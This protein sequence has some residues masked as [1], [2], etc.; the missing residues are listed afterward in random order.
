LNARLNAEQ[1]GAAEI[2]FRVDDLEERL[3]Q[4]GA[5]LEHVKAERAN[6]AG[7]QSSDMAMANLYHMRDL[8]GSKL[9]IEQRV[10][11]EADKRSQA[12]EE[13]LRK[14]SAELERV[15]DELSKQSDEQLVLERKLELQLAAAKTAAEQADATIKAK[16]RVRTPAHRSDRTATGPR[17]TAESTGCSSADCRQGAAVQRGI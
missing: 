14:N 4:N 10:A 11:A 12:V 5:E 13:E 7:Q 8:L 15:K 1:Q 2:K 6:A 17:R 3:R 9:E 16:R